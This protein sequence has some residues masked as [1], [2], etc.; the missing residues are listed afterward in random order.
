MKVELSWFIPCVIYIYRRTREK[1]YLTG[2]NAK[3]E[4]HNGAIGY[5][6]VKL[7]VWNTTIKGWKVDDGSHCHALRRRLKPKLFGDALYLDV[8]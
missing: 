2:A 7:E 1:S 5:R 4:K 3:L 6:A 8:M